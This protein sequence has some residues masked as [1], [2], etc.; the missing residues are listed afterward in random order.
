MKNKETIEE[1]LAQILHWDLNGDYCQGCFFRYF[2]FC[3]KRDCICKAHKSIY[4]D[5][6]DIL[7]EN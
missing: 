5:L 7:Y 2:C 3:I 1:K 4:E 6:T